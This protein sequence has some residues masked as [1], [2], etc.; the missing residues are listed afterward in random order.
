MPKGTPLTEEEF[1]RRRREILDAAM[2]LIVEKGFIETSM[3]EIAAAAGVGKST[4]YDYFP[5]KDD[6]LIAYVVD[7]VKQMSAM[8][9]KIIAMNISAGVKF[10]QIMHKHLEYMLANKLIWL[11]ISFESQ[12]LSYESQQRY[13]IHRHAYQDMLCDL[14]H[15][16]IE[17]GEFRPVNPLLTVRSIFSILSSSVFTTRPTGTPEDM[18]SESFDIIFKGLEMK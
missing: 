15:E 6:I 12:R 7:E 9:K 14:V 18:L 16:G 1:N 5:A 2:H 17:N 3:R 8:A 13:Q 10:R 11:K 4:L